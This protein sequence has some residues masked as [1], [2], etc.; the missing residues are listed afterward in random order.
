[1]PGSATKR[2]IQ[3]AERSFNISSQQERKAFATCIAL[4]VVI[5]IVV[6]GIKQCS[7]LSTK[8]HFSFYFKS[9]CFVSQRAQGDC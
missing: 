8:Q 2:M 6:G 1:M 7:S 9:S 5:V 4:L 3:R